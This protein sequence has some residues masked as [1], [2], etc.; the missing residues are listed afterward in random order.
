MIDV[1]HTGVAHI[2]A[3]LL[4]GKA[5]DKDIGVQNLDALL[6]HVLDGLVNHVC[7]HTIVHTTTGKDNLRIIAHT[8]SALCQIV[9]INRNA[10]TAYQTRIHLDE[11][12]LGSGSLNHIGSVNAHQ[13]EDLGE[14][15]EEGNHNVALRVLN[16]LSS[17]S[18]LDGRS[19]MSTI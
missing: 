18:N 15:I 12:P 4:E 8:H 16:D 1:N 2:R 13:R 14:L 9:R 5:H 10:V 6:E 11:V 19:F 17:F 7:T 3:I